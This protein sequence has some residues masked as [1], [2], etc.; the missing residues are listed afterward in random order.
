MGNSKEVNKPN[1]GTIFPIKK[2]NGESSYEYYFCDFTETLGI[3]TTADVYKG[4][5]CS[6]NSSQTIT[7]LSKVNLSDI[8]IREKPVAIKLYKNGHTPSPYR[9]KKNS[10]QMSI[11]GRAVLI[12]PFIDGF[13]I[14]PESVQN[15][16]IAQFT[17]FQ[18]VDLAWQFVIGLN[19]LHYL[20]NSG[21]PTVHGDISGSNVKIRK[22]GDQYEGF[23]VDDDFSKPI[24]LTPQIVQGS[25]EHIA[26]EVLDGQYSDSSDFYALTPLLYSLF[27]A[28]NPFKKIFQFR[29]SH[30]LMT[31]EDKIRQYTA[32]GF[33]SE[34]LFK[35]FTPKPDA[36]ICRL[37][38]GFLKKMAAREKLQRPT[39]NA[40][41]EFF[42]ALRQHCLV[43]DTSEK[44]F[45]FLRLV[46]AS[47]D[48]NWLK[49][50]EQQTLFFSLERNIQNRLMDLM[51]PKICR[52]LFVICQKNNQSEITSYLLK[53]ILFDLAHQE[54]WGL[55]SCFGFLFKPTVSQNDLK[56]LL[57]CYEH[58]SPV[59]FSPQSSAIRVNLE[60]CKDSELYPFISAAIEELKGKCLFQ[61]NMN[62][63]IEHTGCVAH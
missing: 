13:D 25:P 15:P 47:N 53:I 9:V 46:I 52:D 12:T 56:W 7:C 35:H 48:D 36:S 17:F 21:I 20:N 44:N 19:Q 28:L 18:A 58:K 37:L 63:N 43:E 11:N 23:Y 29:D 34:G 4:Y 42:T 14:K 50:E 5:S 1:Q 40:I 62:E 6:L 61:E 45:N 41:L 51:S 39:S 26:L 2:R 55:F 60:K 27:G 32:I 24:S 3:G 22:N 38:E 31:K 30:P 8:T 16:D 54:R 59:F 57:W 10:V 49:S 33:C